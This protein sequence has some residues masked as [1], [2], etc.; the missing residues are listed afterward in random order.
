MYWVASRNSARH[1]F[2]A[3]QAGETRR[4]TAAA[5]AAAAAAARAALCRL[6]QGRLPTIA[7]LQP[8]AGEIKEKVSKPWLTSQSRGPMASALLTLEWLKKMR[9]AQ[10]NRGSC[11]RFRQALFVSRSGSASVLYD[12]VKRRLSAPHRH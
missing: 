10:I 1:H 7:H 11:R 6:S 12:V 8:S 3:A 4:M 2:E 9:T 5:A